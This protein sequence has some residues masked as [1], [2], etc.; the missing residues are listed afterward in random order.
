MTARPKDGVDPEAI[1]DNA[2]PHEG[3]KA[4]GRFVKGQSGNPGGR[5]KGLHDMQALARQCTEAAI[6]TLADIMRNGKNESARVRASEILL[7]RG[8]GKVAT[9]IEGTNGPPLRLAGEL[10]QVVQYEIP[11]NGRGPRK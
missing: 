4:R 7:D 10:T 9:P 2:R 8:W 5:P 3:V 1:V 11:N 6:V